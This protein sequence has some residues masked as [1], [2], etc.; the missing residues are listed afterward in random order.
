[1]KRETTIALLFIAIFVFA[2]FRTADEKLFN[3]KNLEGW[4]V[5]PAELSGHWT[6]KKGKVLYGENMDKKGSMI[7]TEK[8]YVDYE[9]ELEYRTLSE[10]YDTG[11]FPRGDGH[12]VQ[13]G[14][15]RS[16]QRDMTACIYAPADNRGAYPAQT[17]KVAEFHKLGEWNRLRIIVEGKR[18]QTF[19]NGE[20]FVDYEGIAINGEGPIGLQLHAGVHMA[21]EFR[22]I[23]VRKK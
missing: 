1:M 2:G 9:L 6:V 22:N 11:V 18:I 23:V 15:S 13:I 4:V 7:W 5:D 20:P 12:Q 10:D 16:L 17:D 19:L 14:V 21:V 3:G 8:S